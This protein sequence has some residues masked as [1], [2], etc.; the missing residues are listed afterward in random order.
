[1]CWTVGDES[2]WSSRKLMMS[3]SLDPVSL[4]SQIYGPWQK[5]SPVLFADV[6]DGPAPT[7]GFPVS[8]IPVFLSRDELGFDWVIASPPALSLLKTF[9]SQN[10]SLAWHM[11]GSTIPRLTE[12]HRFQ[13]HRDIW[14]IRLSTCLQK[15]IQ[16]NDHVVHENKTKATRK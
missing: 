7:S 10:G 2:H 14:W 8:M 16:R 15:K 13:Y 3:G 4:T 1:M 6:R 5:L 11:Q 9:S 12:P